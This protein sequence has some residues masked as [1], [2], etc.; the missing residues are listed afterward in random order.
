M[1]RHLGVFSCTLLMY[2]PILGNWLSSLRFLCAP[3]SVGRI[4]GT[5]IFRYAIFDVKPGQKLTSSMQ[6]ALIHPR[7][8]RFRG[9]IS[10]VMGSRIRSV[11]LRTLRLA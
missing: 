4:I 9:R 1:G 3:S 2:V 7:V 8:S 10:D 11:L 6:Y 5:G